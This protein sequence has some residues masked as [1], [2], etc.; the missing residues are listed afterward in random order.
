MCRRPPALSARFQ[1]CPEWEAAPP[2]Q[3]P[4]RRAGSWGRAASS[5]P[6][7]IQASIGSAPAFFL[8]QFNPGTEAGLHL[9]DL[10]LTPNYHMNGRER[11]QKALTPTDPPSPLPASPLSPSYPLAFL[12]GGSSKLRRGKSNKAPSEETHCHRLCHGSPFA[13]HCSPCSLTCCVEGCEQLLVHSPDVLLK[14]N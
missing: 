9:T 11:L 3:H 14:N 4:G 6:N 10:C 8:L 13:S 12:G 1:G 5:R 2:A 7:D